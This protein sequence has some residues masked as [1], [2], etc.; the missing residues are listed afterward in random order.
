M[1][2]EKSQRLLAVQAAKQAVIDAAKSQPE[3]FVKG[4]IKNPHL[5]YGIQDIADIFDILL[6]K[7]QH[8]QLTCLAGQVGVPKQARAILVAKLLFS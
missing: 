7:G 8:E 1:Q 4:M 2:T 5:I 6:S 3:A